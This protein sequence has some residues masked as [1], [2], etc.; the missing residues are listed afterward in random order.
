MAYPTIDSS[1]CTGCRMCVDACPA[2][3]LDL[4]DDVAVLVHPDDCTECN[5]CAESC[6]MGAIS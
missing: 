6:P 1:E 3:A 4:V 2:D 5:L